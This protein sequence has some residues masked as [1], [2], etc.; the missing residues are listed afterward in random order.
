MPAVVSALLVF[1]SFVESVEQSIVPVAQLFE[2]P[3]SL[4]VKKYSSN[5][6]REIVS[7]L[8]RK[9]EMIRVVSYNVLFPVYDHQLA[10]I[11]RWPQ[12]VTRVAELIEEMDADVIAVQE[13]LH[14]QLV[15][16]QPYLSQRY[17]FFSRA[18]KTGELNGFF[19]RK[20]RFEVTETKVW[21]RTL[22][23]IQLRDLKTNRCFAVFN[24]HLAF[25]DI[26]KRESQ[27]RFIADIVDEY[28]P[29]MPVILA[30]DMNTFPQRP[31]MHFPFLDGDYIQRILTGGTLKDAR[32]IS[33][34]G[35]LGPL[36]TYTNTPNEVAPF[37]GLGTPG[38]FLDHIYVNSKVTV[39]LHAVE[40]GKVN[41]HYPSDH[42][43]LFIDCVID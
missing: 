18:G 5:Q 33:V 13:L 32:E 30:G 40:T 36:S 15:D 6:Y 39:L 14:E 4:D 35:H 22:T 19:Y 41:G 17:A 37:K 1:C 25:T 34:L 12:R 21:D 28:S 9:H 23:M 2:D 8:E 27:A 29:R 26:E 31:E 3:K 38:V 16:L 10:K 24:T 42:M 11:N 7:A 43:P 20:E